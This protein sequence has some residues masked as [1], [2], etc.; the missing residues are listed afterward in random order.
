MHKGITLIAGLLLALSATSPARADNYKVDPVHSTIAFRVIHLNVAPFYGL[1]LAPAGTFVT[2]EDPA[3]M[4]FDVT[5]AVDKIYTGNDKR[6]QDLKS[7]TWLGAKQFPNITFK[8]TSVKKSG[9]NAYEVTGDFTLHGV[10][11]SITVIVNKTGEGP[12]MK[13]ETRSGWESIFEIKR[14]DYGINAMPGGISD[15]IKLMIGLEGIKQ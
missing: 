4:K 8:S 14:S 9:D 11:K 3:K 2:D 6:D 13:G 7:Q 1:F 10:T 5:V 15:E 12:G